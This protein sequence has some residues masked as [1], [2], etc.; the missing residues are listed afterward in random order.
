LENNEV[1]NFFLANRTSEVEGALRLIEKGLRASA[2]EAEIKAL[3][4]EKVRLENR[5]ASLGREASK[6]KRKL[7]EKEGK[8]QKVS[9]ENQ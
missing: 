8:V 1:I 2:M 4:T 3:K 7:K 5:L 6:A 9:E